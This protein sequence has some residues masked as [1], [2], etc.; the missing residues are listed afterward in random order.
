MHREAAWRGE[1]FPGIELCRLDVRDGRAR[2]QGSVAYV[3][4][5]ETGLLS[6]R[7]HLTPRW[8]TVDV[9]LRRLAPADDPVT[10]LLSRD[11]AGRWTVNG[12]PRPD[13]EGCADVDLEF[14]PS[15]NTLPIRRLDMPEGCSAPVLAAWVRFPALTV[16]VIEQTYERVSEH[17]Y[18]YRAGSFTADLEVD[19]AGLVLDY[20]GI[21]RRVGGS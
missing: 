20:P 21:W 8:Q 12:T 13:L 3:D 10:R 7:I 15:T 19:E 9:A 17:G 4:G 2:L 5:G 16:E 11:D 18:R 6:Y 1:T 14:S